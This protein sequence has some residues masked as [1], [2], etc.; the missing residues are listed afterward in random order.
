MPQRPLV[1]CLT[2]LIASL[3]A[4][5]GRL[6]DLE[7]VDRN[8]GNTLDVHR[9]RGQDWIAG[10][11]GERYAVRLVNRTGQRVLVVLSVDGVNAVSG[12]TAAPDQSGYVLAPWER[13]EIAGWRKSLEEIAQFYFTALPDAYAA[14]TGRPHHVGVIGAAVFREKTRLRP[15]APYPGQPAPGG[16]E[17]RSAAAA[18]ARDAPAA[19]AQ[20]RREAERLGTGHGEREYAPIRYTVFERSSAS[21]A[22]VLSL[23]YDSHENL[24]LRGVLVRPHPDRSEPRPFPGLFVPDPGG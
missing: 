16:N 20:A 21:P 10:S 5:A 13:A 7:I 12:E 23:R 18:D 1:L 22:E 3:P 9:H 15:V 19:M 24:V 6:L 17:Q 2:L 11:P 4:H 14:R 8:T